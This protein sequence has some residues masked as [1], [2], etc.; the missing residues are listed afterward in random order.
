MR[1]CAR[2]SLSPAIDIAGLVILGGPMQE[3]ANVAKI[4][5][6]SAIRTLDG[7]KHL[8]G[9]RTVNR[10]RLRATYRTASMAYISLALSA[11]FSRES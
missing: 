7:R 1:S 8:E 5:T 11:I 2:M 9:W 3:T 4:T 10:V 6:K